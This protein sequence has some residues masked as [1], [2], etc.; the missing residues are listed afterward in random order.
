M[1]VDQ[2]FNRVGEKLQQLLKDHRRLQRENEKLHEELAAAQQIIEA[3]ESRVQSL[4]QQMA[5]LKLAAGEMDEKEKKV[6]EKKLNQYIRDVEK[7]IAAL[8]E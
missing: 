3:G 6:F 2:D 5:V 8:S 7:V 4:Q 1:S